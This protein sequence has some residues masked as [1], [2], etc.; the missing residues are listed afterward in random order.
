MRK[1][2]FTDGF[3]LSGIVP[4]KQFPTFFLGDDFMCQTE[5][6]TLASFIHRLM[7]NYLS[8]GYFFY[9]V[10]EIPEHKD[11]AKTDGK[12]I[13]QYGIAI[14]KWAR[15][16]ARKRGEAS[17]Q[18]HRFGRQFVILA[19]SGSHRFFTEEAKNI[20]DV[21]R[22]PLKVAGCVV[23]YRRG[24]DAKPTLNVRREPRF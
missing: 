19:T 22:V 4:D 11:P 9:V 17:V 1:G 16:R 3:V 10:G 23:S 2:F 24:E 6:K 14:S 20:R 18:Y 13:G 12:I 8:R 7:A 21:R 5:A 15:A